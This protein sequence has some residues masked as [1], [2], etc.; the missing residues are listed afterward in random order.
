MNMIP[1]NGASI[2]AENPDITAPEARIIWHAAL[3]PGTLC[4]TI[5]PVDRRNPDRVRLAALAPWLTVVVDYA[6]REHAVL[7]DGWHHIRLDI[8]GGSLAGGGS[9]LFA[10]RLG[11]LTSARTRLLPL[12]RFLDLAEHRRFTSTLFPR[13]PRIARWLL[14][15][16]IHDALA[17][18]A[19]QREIGRELFGAGQVAL[20]WRGQSDALRSRVRRL[21]QDAAA[22]ARGG[23]RLLM[24]RSH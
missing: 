8:E 19:S 16:R 2:F 6:G 20:N 22:M 4:V 5:T 12:R 1:S 24:R 7:S 18:G 13:D 21:A 3:D 15:L 14:L 9:A 23:Y 17:V 11:G 10:Y